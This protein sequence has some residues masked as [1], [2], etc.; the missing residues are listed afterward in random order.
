[1]GSAAYT[2]GGSAT[3]VVNDPSGFSTTTGLSLVGGASVT[4]GALEL[5]DGFT[6]TLR[7]AAAGVQAVGISGGNLG[8]AGIGS[9]VAVKFDLYDNAGE[10]MTLPAFWMRAPTPPHFVRIGRSG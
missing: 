2:I 9:S 6:F 3:T 5:T 4:G 10:G 7:N 8:Y 1:V